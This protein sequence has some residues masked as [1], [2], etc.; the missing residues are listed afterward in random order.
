LSSL[1]SSAQGEAHAFAIEEVEG[2]HNS[3]RETLEE[4]LA[5]TTTTVPSDIWFHLSE[6]LRLGAR[7]L[8]VVTHCIHEWAEPPDDRADRDDH[9]DPRDAALQPPERKRRED[10][11]AG[12]RNLY[13]W[14][15]PD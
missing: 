9:T 3:L 12:R 5:L 6:R 2:L 14:S 8:G 13:S 15:D 11:R 7:R 10:R 1:R 4:A